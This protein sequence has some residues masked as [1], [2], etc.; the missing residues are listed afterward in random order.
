MEGRNDAYFFALSVTSP[1]P[2]VR[3]R[4][5]ELS[6]FQQ[7]HHFPAPEKKW[8]LTLSLLNP[9]LDKVGQR[10]PAFRRHGQF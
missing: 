3:R 1:D 5:P 4:E 6:P 9:Y 8:T 7:Q 10:R 2:T